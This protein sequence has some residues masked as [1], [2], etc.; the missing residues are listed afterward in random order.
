MQLGVNVD[1]RHGFRAGDI[2]A[3]GVAW[4]RTVLTPNDDPS[5][6]SGHSLGPW[7][8]DCHAHGLK[9]LGVI[10]RE[11]FRRGWTYKHA[12]R[13]YAAFFDAAASLESRVPSL[14][15]GARLETPDSRPETR[16]PITAAAEARGWWRRGRWRR[17][18]GRLGGWWLGR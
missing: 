8:E 17:R 5:T 14:G 6:G 1:P 16:I 13:Y 15:S 11:S 10:A 4:V 12:A 2:A 9:V 7:I 18:A 3:P